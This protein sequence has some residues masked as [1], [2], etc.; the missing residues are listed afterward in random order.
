MPTTDFG[1]EFEL[2]ALAMCLKDPRYMRDA[3]RVLDRRHFVI[4]EHGWAWKVI[5]DT[6]RSSSEIPT[7]SVFKSKLYTEMD[8]EDA[9]LPYLNLIVDIFRR[10]PQAPKAALEELRQ[11]VRTTD[12]Q[13]AIEKSIKAQERHQWNEA[14]DPIREAVRKDV[15]QSGYRVSR[16]IEEFDERQRER[17]HRYEHPELYKT[18]PTGFRE[19]DRRLG[20]AREGELW[21]IMASTNR[22]KS[23][24]AVN[25]GFNALARGYS[26][27]H[28]TTEMSESKVAQRYDSR[29]TQFEY[30]KFKRWDFSSNDLEKING[31]VRDKT[32]R[33]KGKLRIVATP[34]R[35][36]D[37]DLIHNAI[38][39]MRVEMQS[40]I[41]MVIV[42]SGDHIQ[43]R[44][45]F[46]KQYLYE[47]ANYWDLKDLAEDYE[48]VTYS[49]LQAKA[50]FEEK[51]A[52]TRAS[53][54]AYAKS[55][56][57]DVLISINETRKG[58]NRQ[59]VTS[60]SGE[61]KK[62]QKKK[63]DRPG[64]LELFVAKCRDDE[65]KFFIPIETKLQTM[66]IRDY[67]EGIDDET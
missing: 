11:F 12:L 39:D 24:L 63:K 49:T 47:G 31:I 4:P 28:F 59:T 29:F 32:N 40:G 19:L 27:V 16:W 3:V 60:E 57:V 35:N 30:R 21:G 1:A 61:P 5:S 18:I 38:D 67:Q 56:I 66:L 62:E 6:W 23:I 58:K 2:D 50:E 8:D 17:K 37:M 54:G 34:L 43:Q 14:W 45:R 52:T 55:Q 20:G 51:V 7:A 13:L 64:G 44:G 42:D 48:L 15:R 53:G 46:E 65:S 33:Y 9:R 10:E 25:I 41:D 36:C 22:G 26:V